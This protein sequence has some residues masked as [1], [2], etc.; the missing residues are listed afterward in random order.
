M[1]IALPT[2]RLCL[3]HRQAGSNL[4]KS[5]T[6]L[7]PDDSPLLVRDTSNQEVYA[8]DFQAP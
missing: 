2:L 1:L 8:L 7:A 3:D 4:E 6:G 5:R